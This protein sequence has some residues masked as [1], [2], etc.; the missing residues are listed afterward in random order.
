MDTLDTESTQ[1]LLQYRIVI[2]G[3]G[4]A[5][6]GMGALLRDL[7]IADFMILDRLEIGSSFRQ[8]PKQMRFITPSFTSNGF[9]LLDLNAVTTTTSPA[10]TLEEEHPSGEQYAR[11]LTGVADHYALPVKTGVDVMTVQPVN[12]DGYPCSPTEGKGFRLYT[13]QGQI[14]TQFV[15]WAAGEFQY[16]NLSPFSGSEYCIHTATLADYAQLEGEEYIV[17]GGYESGIDA[18]INLA[19]LGRPV[20]VLDDYTPWEFRGPD[21][22]LVLAPYTLSRLRTIRQTQNVELKSASVVEVKR[23]G[24]T[25]VINCADG[26]R[27]HTLSPPLL[28]TGFTS[29]LSTINS[30]FE[31]HPSDSY[32]LLTEEDESTLT[33]GLFLT[34]PFVRHQ[35]KIFCFIYKFRQRFAV[36]GN[37]IAQRIGVDTSPLERYR[38]FNMYLDDLTC[39]EDDCVSC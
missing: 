22:S 12:D 15:I 28:A 3:A 9:N 6:I 16:P 1:S 24:H 13:S 7:D 18:A 25:Y 30:L 26:E 17:I 31:W 39:C 19:Q 33:P 37:A 10:F 5:G 38:Q 2:V 35:N 4:A 29:S 34:G 20:R 23:I 36:V 8:W 11:Y 14:E 32:A 27:F 21:P